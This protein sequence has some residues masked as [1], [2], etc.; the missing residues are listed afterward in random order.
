MMNTTNIKNL[1]MYAG[2]GMLLAAPAMAQGDLASRERMRRMNSIRE[3]EMHLTDGRAAYAKG[4]YETAVNEYRA[5]LDKTP[6]GSVGATR[7]QAMTEH[8]TDGS[9]ALAQ[10]HRKV[11]KYDEARELLEDVLLVDPGNALANQE[12]D[13]LDD[14]IRTNPALTYEHTQD[15]DR[16]RRLLYMGEGY[17]NLGQFDKAEVE[18]NN[19][20]KIDKYN[21]AARRWLERCASIRSDYYRS[22]YDH[23][24]AHLLAEVDKAWELTVQADGGYEEQIKGISTGPARKGQN[25]SNKLKSII[26]PQVEM[27]D[28]SIEEAIDELRMRSRELDPEV[29]PTRKGINFII[30]EPKKPVAGEG[31]DLGLAPEGEL[32]AADPATLRISELKLS[33]IPLIKVLDAICDQTG[34]RYRIDEYAVTLLPRGVDESDEVIMKTWKVTPTFLSD[35]GGADTGG[36]AAS[37]DP[38]AVGGGDS[39]ESSFKSKSIQ[40][41]LST[42][43]VSFDQGASASFLKG[44]STLIVHNTINNLDLVDDIVSNIEGKTP[45]QIKILTKFVEVSQDNTDEIGFDWNLSVPGTGLGMRGGSV[46]NGQA[47]NDFNFAG[48]RVVSS[49]LRSGD[50]AITRDSIVNL[51]ANQST[52]LQSTSSA[53]GILSVGGILSGNTVEMIFRGLSQK[54]GVDIMTA[55]HVVARSGETAKIEIVREFIY[56]TEYDPPELPDRVTATG[57][58]PVTPA[59]PTAFETRNTGVSLEVLPQTGDTNDYVINLEFRPEVVEFE[60]FI[61]YGSPITGTTED[62]ESVII[63]ENR[64]EMPVFATRKIETAITIFDG[65]TVAVGGLMRE[66]VQNVEDKIPILGDIP[67]IGRLFQSKSESRIKSNLVMFVTAQVIDATG[68]PIRSGAGEVDTEIDELFASDA[69]LLPPLN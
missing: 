50:V 69:G 46:G 59:T 24:R 14:P 42:A 6:R 8:L 19:V 67:L 16:V 47:V 13:Y 9:V 65:Y 64:I 36:S 28:I 2:L 49:G 10:Q 56:P 30:R 39:S 62:G 4:D 48:G 12:L 41:L 63:T 35:L 66:D 52:G 20:L 40:E 26:L 34:L 33:N 1:T 43:G 54:K 68:T 53:P 17:Y 18:F 15:V 57:V 61:N 11:G 22:A 38:F 21:K 31:D 5:A 58:F 60:G 25:I 32:G 27:V 3:A 51:I 44:T 29:D 45:K 23:T 37:S 55:P 7:R